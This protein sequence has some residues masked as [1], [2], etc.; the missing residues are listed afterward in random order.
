MFINQVG[1][2]D[3]EFGLGLVDGGDCSQTAGSDS[4]CFH[5][6]AARLVSVVWLGA[7]KKSRAWKKAGSFWAARIKSG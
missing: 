5:Y 2:A 3:L 4:T 6:T 7:L 1:K